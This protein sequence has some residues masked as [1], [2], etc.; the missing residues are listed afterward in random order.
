MRPRADD[1]SFFPHR[2]ELAT[3]VEVEVPPL[4]LRKDER[5]RHEIQ[6][7][8]QRDE[9]GL[10]VSLLSDQSIIT[11]I[12]L[13]LSS[14]PD[15]LISIG[16][17]ILDQPSNWIED[18]SSISDIVGL[19]KNFVL[20][21]VDPNDEKRVDKGDVWTLAR[22]IDFLAQ[23]YGWTI[24]EILDRT[25]WELK[26]II[27]AAGQRYEEQKAA[28]EESSSGRRQSSRVR[29]GTGKRSFVQPGRPKNVSEEETQASIQALTSFAKSRGSYEKIDNRAGKQS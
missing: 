6:K 10:S 29:T 12:A 18:H 22:L 9:A 27:E 21:P 3:G 1:T 19:V 15:D 17:M 4:T 16:A 24:D 25:R 23:E 8:L 5:V 14:A 28:M 7:I 13:S 11:L 20:T 26:A 2:V